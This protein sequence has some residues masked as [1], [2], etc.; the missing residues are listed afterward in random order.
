MKKLTVSILPLLLLLSLC[1]CGS[2][3]TTYVC[4]SETFYY[5]DGTEESYTYDYD[6]NG[7]LIRSLYE[8]YGANSNDSTSTEAIMTYGNVG[9]PLEKTSIYSSDSITQTTTTVYDYNDK[10]DTIPVS[11]KSYDEDGSIA[12]TGTYE[13]D[14]STGTVYYTQYDGTGEDV[15]YVNESQYLEEI[16]TRRRIWGNIFP[17]FRVTN[18]TIYFH[19]FSLSSIHYEFERDDYA[20]MTR[21]TITLQSDTSENTVTSENTYTYEYN[22]EDLPIKATIY[23]DGEIDGYIEYEYVL[24]SDYLRGK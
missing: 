15:S 20:C 14:D 21:R 7:D 9:Q 23:C 5:A 16:P 13:Y 3:D 24:L 12:S 10:N 17:H 6:E 2:K 22:E 4:I 8:Y 19:D 11:C 1:G 18:E